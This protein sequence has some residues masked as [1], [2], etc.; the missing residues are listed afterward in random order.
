MCKQPRKKKIQLGIFPIDDVLPFCGTGKT[1]QEYIGSD[2]NR[3]VVRLKSLR[4][5][6]FK[7]SLQCCCCGL[8]GEFFKL[9]MI[10]DD[11]A[12]HFN[13]YGVKNGKH[14]MF[15]KDHIVPK[16]KGGKDHISNMQTMCE[17]CN[18]FKK[19]LE[20]PFTV[21]NKAR[22]IHDEKGMDYARNWLSQQMHEQIGE[23][24]VEKV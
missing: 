2:G 3:Y 14:I 8:E 12:P 15:T 13:L 7:K 16:S 5:E 24:E 10:E 23:K 20:I 19:D 9:E 4:Y 11:P 22:E 6:T 21:L 1:R 18:G 17:P